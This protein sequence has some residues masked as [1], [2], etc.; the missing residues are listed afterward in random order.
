ME[1][2]ARDFSNIRAIAPQ[3]SLVL[4]YC[5]NTEKCRTVTA[6]PNISWELD[7]QESWLLRITCLDCSASWAVCRSCRQLDNRLKTKTA[8]VNHRFRYHK[9]TSE[10]LADSCV[11]VIQSPT[12]S[13]KRNR[14][15]EDVAN[16]H[17][18]VEN[19]QID[20]LCESP[21]IAEKE[22]NA[23]S[24]VSCDQAQFKKMLFCVKISLILLFLFNF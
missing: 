15:H 13:N 3:T 5:P 10:N 21:A 14:S 20:M 6:D 2:K 7:D 12:C 16:P 19:L 8:V 18:D 24:K 23:T 22:P 1:G 17:E 9:R 4:F 11:P